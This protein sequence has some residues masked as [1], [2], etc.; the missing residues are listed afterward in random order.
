[1]KRALIDINILLDV[2]GCRQPHYNA[3]AA[4][5]SAAETRRFEGMVSADSFSTLYYLLRQQSDHRTAMRG[6]RLVGD[7]FSIIALDEQI[8]AQAMNSPVKDFEDA[9][10]YHS[11]LRGQA[12]CIVTRDLRHFRAADLPAMPPDAFPAWLES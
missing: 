2:L 11:A 3:A 10:Q 5:W 8:I 1:M 9:I 4:V 6:I 12:E 7:V